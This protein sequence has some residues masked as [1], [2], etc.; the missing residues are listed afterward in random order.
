MPS[1]IGETGVE[2]IVHWPKV[3]QVLFGGEV[4]INVAVSAAELMSK[5]KGKGKGTE[6]GQ[7]IRWAAHLLA[8][9]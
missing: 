9:V 8:R 1:L 2:E 7:A 3:R 4:R 6:Q 5:G